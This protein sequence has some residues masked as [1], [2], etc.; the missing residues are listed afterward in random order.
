MFRRFGVQQHLSEVKSAIAT[1]MQGSPGCWL[2]QGT[3]KRGESCVR[4]C[5]R[6]CVM[7]PTH[8]LCDD[9]HLPAV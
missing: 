8:L 1:P 2:L 3:L 9:P 6:R 4:A 7:S 5:G